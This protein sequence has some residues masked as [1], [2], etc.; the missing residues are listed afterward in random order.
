MKANPKTYAEMNGNRKE[1]KKRTGNGLN[2]KWKFSWGKE[3]Q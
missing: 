2:K 1:R 3:M